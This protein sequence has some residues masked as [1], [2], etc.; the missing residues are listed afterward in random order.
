MCIYVYIK[1]LS[2]SY[3]AEDDVRSASCPRSVLAIC[4][5]A[6]VTSFHILSQQFDV[7]ATSSASPA[8]AGLPPN[9]SII[10]YLNKLLSK[11]RM[12]VSHG[13]DFG[14]VILRWKK[15]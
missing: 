10:S 12:Q 2:C 3:G 15:T 4:G 5:D 13:I 6:P 14:C 9:I 11:Q 8:A 1:A 7:L